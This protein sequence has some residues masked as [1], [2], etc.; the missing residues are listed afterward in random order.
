VR[1]QRGSVLAMAVAGPLTLAACSS[2]GHD[3]SGTPSAEQ[4]TGGS[5]TSGPATPARQPIK[6]G[7]ATSLTGNFASSYAKFDPSTTNLFDVYGYGD[8]GNVSTTL[9]DYFKERS[10]TKLATIG[11]GNSPNSV[12][13]PRNAVESAKAVG[14]EVLF[15]DTTL[16]AG[17]TNV[18]PLMQKQRLGCRFRME[19]WP[20]RRPD[21]QMRIRTIGLA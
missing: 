3:T 8:Q 19:W 15:V 1:Y 9:G 20:R 16:S 5:E 13:G 7:V 4:S 12:R 10:V 2:S 17:S 18:G 6:V 21:T 11:Y 14:I